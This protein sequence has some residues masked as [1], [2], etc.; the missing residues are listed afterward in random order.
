MKGRNKISPFDDL[1]KEL[2]AADKFLKKNHEEILKERN[3]NLQDK[4][5][6]T[7]KNFD[8]D[9]KQNE[10]FENLDPLFSKYQKRLKSYGFPLIGSFTSKSEEDKEKIFQ[11]FDYIIN[12]KF[13]QNEEV[14]KYKKQLDILTNKLNSFISENEK[15][16]KEISSLQEDNKKFSKEKKDY[17]TKIT[18]SKELLEKQNSE[19]KNS[20]T[21]L[22]NKFNVLQIEKKSIEEKYNKI[23]DVYQKFTNRGPIINLKPNNSIEMIEGLKRNDF[24]KR[25]SKVKG[26][27]KLVET[28]KNGYN[29]SLRELLFEVSALKSFISEVNLDLINL[30]KSTKYSQEGS[31]YKQIENNLFNMPFLDTVNK[32]KSIFKFNINYLS[33][34]LALEE[35]NFE[36]PI[37]NE[38]FLQ[39]SQIN[40]NRSNTVTINENI[41]SPSER[42]SNICEPIFSLD[43]TKRQNENEIVEKE[44]FESE[45]EFLKKKWVQTLMRKDQETEEEINPGNT[46]Y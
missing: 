19:L 36:E 16:Q 26:T 22:S 6:I 38:K 13:N 31:N 8:G 21:K 30:I 4:D 41:I 46:S 28:F 7:Y 11:F 17:E 39:I 40:H 5:F 27:E 37:S 43:S 25:L 20:F 1:A 44:D 2:Q 12:Q 9:L 24:L 29:E 10:N 42:F 32:I 3:N 35:T 23:S 33:K 45:L 18:K 14:M 34:C 15:L